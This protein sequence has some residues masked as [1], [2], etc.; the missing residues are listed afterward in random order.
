ML[1]W[2]GYWRLADRSTGPDGEQ[3]ADAG[4]TLSKADRD[5]RKL[6]R[7]TNPLEFRARQSRHARRA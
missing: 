6:V 4:G 5:R 7:L 3:Q 2:T 1:Q